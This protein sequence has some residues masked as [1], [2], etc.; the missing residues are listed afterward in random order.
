MV[1]NIWIGQPLAKKILWCDNFIS[2]WFSLQR[3]GSITRSFFANKHSNKIQTSFSWCEYKDSKWLMMTR[4]NVNHHMKWYSRQTNRRSY[5]PGL[6]F[7]SIEIGSTSK[8]DSSAHS[9][10]LLLD[11]L[12]FFIFLIFSIHLLLDSLRFIFHFLS[13]HKSLDFLPLL[14]FH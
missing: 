13:F 6:P 3:G 11:S 14:H 4:L 10:R 8:L 1:Q 7:I 5:R 12:D 2:N 9:I